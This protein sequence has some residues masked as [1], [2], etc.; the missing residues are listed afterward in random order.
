MTEKII[1]WVRDWEC[2]CGHKWTAPVRLSDKTTNLS[3]EPAEYCPACGKR[4]WIG[5]P[6]RKVEDHE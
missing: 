5:Y 2:T 3:G 1:G 4:G 6:A